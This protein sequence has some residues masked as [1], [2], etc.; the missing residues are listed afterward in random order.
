V[1]KKEGDEHGVEGERRPRLGKRV[2]LREGAVRIDAEGGRPGSSANEHTIGLVEERGSR[3]A[4]RICRQPKRCTARGI[5]QNASADAAND[6]VEGLSVLRI[7]VRPNKLATGKL[8]RID[9]IVV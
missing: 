8:A 2:A 5:Q 7:G 3:D 9:A 6:F 4:R 1:A